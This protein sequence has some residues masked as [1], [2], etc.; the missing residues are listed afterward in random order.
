VPWETYESLRVLGRQ[1]VDNQ[2]IFVLNNVMRTR[3]M[4]R[5]GTTGL[6]RVFQTVPF[7]L[8]VNRRDMPGYIP[9]GEAFGI[10]GFERSG[11]AR[12]YRRAHPDKN[13]KEL[14]ASNPSIL[15]LLLI[16]SAGSVGHTQASDLDYW[17]LVDRAELKTKRWDVLQEKLDAITTWAAKSHR[18]EV[19]FFLMDIHELRQN[20]LGDI[21]EESSGDVMPRLLKEEFYRTLVHAAGKIPLWWVAPLGL[22][23][24]DYEHLTERVESIELTTLHG[25]D[26]LDMGYPESPEPGEYL[27]AAMWQAYK[28]LRDPFKAVLKM[29]L[30]QEQVATDFRAPLLCD[31]VKNAVLNS[32][33]DQLPID[34]YL[35]TIK[36]VLAFA[37]RDLDLV[38]ISAWF[39]MRTIMDPENPEKD[40]KA[41]LLKEYGRQWGWDDEKIKDLF[42]Y[43]NWPERRKLGL[44]AKIKDFLLDL[45]SGIAGNLRTRY[46]DHASM[47]SESL[48]RL[49]AQ[50]LAQY[51]QD[52]IRVENL[53]SDF[54]RRGLPSELVIVHNKGVWRLLGP[55]SH[56]SDFIYEAPTIARLA[57]WLVHNRIWKKNFKLHIRSS[58][59]TIKQ[60]AVSGLAFFLTEAFPPIKMNKKVEGGFLPKPVGN[61][62]LVVNMENNANDLLLKTA[63][64]I[65]RT[66]LGEL[67]H[68][69]LPI[70][71]NS[72]AQKYVALAGH[73]AEKGVTDSKQIRVYAPPGGLRDEV[74]GNLRAALRNYSRAAIE[75]KAVSR[76]K[77]RLDTD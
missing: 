31:Q 18:T 55:A 46:P 24:S 66:S 12:Q 19:H 33:P 32:S 77:T 17:V 68:Q 23:Q 72:E 60:S 41:D 40:P 27:G 51:G 2:K 73:I 69:V 70:T 38:R 25:A 57:A 37:D 61:V 35:M 43:V 14:L 22:N 10:Y 20:Q 11:F 58:E 48:T 47:Q 29:I 67:H 76:S 9:H 26:Y 52:T 6:K 8:Q 15:S 64:L 4:M 36:R 54:H 63:E 16:G 34:P 49:S 65:Y 28:A 13:L 1:M 62:V 59:K 30:I 50:I 7:L 71:G 53:P 56:E 3:D 74:A 21:G 45:Y 39:K 44:G 75:S 42:T 5:Y